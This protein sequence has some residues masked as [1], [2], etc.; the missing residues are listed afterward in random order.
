M[1]FRL[2]GIIIALIVILSVNLAHSACFTWDNYNCEAENATYYRLY[3]EN[4]LFLEFSCVTDKEVII[5]DNIPEGIYFLRA[6]DSINDLE[7]DNSNEVLIG[8]YYFNKIKYERD[9]SGRLIYMGQHTDQNALE[10][11]TNWVIHKYY[12]DSNG[13]L[14]NIRIRDNVSWANRMEGW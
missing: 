11:D 13:L 8:Q 6:Y 12:Y 2:F 5:I 3:Y 14:I 1:I 7:S 9:S 4:E 10:S